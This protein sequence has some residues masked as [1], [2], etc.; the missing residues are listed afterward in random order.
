M[1]YAQ[2]RGFQ[3]GSGTEGY[4]DRIQART[5]EVIVMADKDTAVGKGDAAEKAFDRKMKS[6]GW[7]VVIKSTRSMVKIPNPNPASRKFRPFI[8]VQKI[9]DL[10]NSWDRIYIRDNEIL[11]AQVTDRHDLARHRKHIEQNFPIIL[12]VPNMRAII[13]L[14]RKVQHGKV[15]RFEFD[16]VSWEYSPSLKKMVWV[17]RQERL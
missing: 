7:K 2:D 5:V 11:F 9:V 4:R 6:E 10:A 12:N 3:K 15:E 14:W 1:E 13:P 16:I 17:E 8:Y